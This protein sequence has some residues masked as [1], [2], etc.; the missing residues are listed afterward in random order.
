MC[1]KT[2]PILICSNFKPCSFKAKLY[3]DYFWIGVTMKCA[4]LRLAIHCKY[5]PRN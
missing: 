5:Y 3:M 4:Y 2:N 1:V